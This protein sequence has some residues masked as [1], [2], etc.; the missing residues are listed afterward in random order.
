MSATRTRLRACRVHRNGPPETDWSPPS[1]SRVLWPSV[2]PE[3]P[4]PL[5][6]PVVAVR[7]RV[8]E[9][10]DPV[11]PDLH[12][13]RVRV[14]VR[15]DGQE[16]V[17]AAVA[18][19]PDL[20]AP[21]RAG[22]SCPASAKSAGRAAGRAR[23]VPV[24]SAGA[25]RPAAGCA[26]RCRSPP[27]TRRAGRTRRRRWPAARPSGRCR[28]RPRPDRARRP[29]R[30]GAAAAGGSSTTAASA[31][32]IRSSTSRI[33]AGT[34]APAASAS[35]T[36]ARPSSST[37]PWYSVASS[38][39]RP[40]GKVLLRSCRSS[41]R[42]ASAPPARRGGEPGERAGRGELP[43]GLG[44]DVVVRR[45]PPAGEGGQPALVVPD[46]V[47]RHRVALEQ[48]GRARP[49]VEQPADPHPGQQPDAQLDAAG[50]VHAAQ[51]RVGRPPRPQ[52]LGHPL[53]VPLVPGDRVGGGEHGE[54]LVPGRLPDLLDVPDRVL[55]AVRH[56]EGV[57]PGAR[58][59][60][61]GSYHQS[62]S[63]RSSRSTP[64]NSACP[65]ISRSASA[66]RRFAASGGT[67]AIVP[68]GSTAVNR[69]PVTLGQSRPRRPP[70]PPAHRVARPAA[71]LPRP[72]PGQP[73]QVPARTPRL[74]VIGPPP[75]SPARRRPGRPARRGWPPWWRPATPAAPAS[76]RRSARP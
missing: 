26:R 15:G 61:F 37:R 21:D 73:P 71:D 23:P 51:R 76:A 66:T 65:A 27:A 24:A 52:V 39:L 56:V 74:T 30:P 62:G 29:R 5:G 42:S 7:P 69:A 63:A 10:V 8:G 54:V 19:A 13:Q 38:R 2:E 35:A 47:Q 44:D 59:P 40:E 22:W 16:A 57:A 58:R 67:A 14:G 72:H 4:P 32:V 75:A 60:V 1:S 9:H 68:A 33:V 55:V 48:G 46:L 31:S 34:G 11:V 18:A 50:P 28:R 25:A 49:A 20:S 43:G 53:G 12:G 64:K 17:R 6:L 3:V 36:A 45:G 70:P 41:D